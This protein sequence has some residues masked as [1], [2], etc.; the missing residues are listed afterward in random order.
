MS[1]Q[2]RSHSSHLLAFLHF[3][4]LTPQETSSSWNWRFY[5]VATLLFLGALL[6]K[7]AVCCL[8]VAI[9]VLIWWKQDRLTARDV[10]NL[11]PWFA[12]S[13]ILGLIMVRVE[14]SPANASV[15]TMPLS[16]VE[17]CLLAGRALCFYAARLFWPGKLTFVYPRWRIDGGAAWQYFFPVMALAVVVALWSLRRRIGKGPLAGVLCFAA[18]LSPVLGFCGVYYFR[19]SYVADHFQYVASIG[20]ISL[21]VCT[22]TAICLRAGHWGRSLGTVAAAI[23]LLALGWSTWGQTRI[24]QNLETLWRDTLTK[25]P[26]CWMAYSNLGDAFLLE[27]RI[28][29]AIGCYEQALRIKPDYFEAHCN[30][31]SALEQTG[32]I[33]EAIG[34][35]Q[36]ALRIKPDYIEAHN[37]LG[38]ALEQAGRVKEAIEHYEQALRID[39][40]YAEAHCNLGSALAQTGKFE[41]AIGHFEEALRIKPDFAEAHNNLGMALEQTGKV[42]EAIGHYQQALRINPDFTPAQN[43]LT[44]LQARQ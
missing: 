15:T 7:T 5:P 3:R 32:K 38:I 30:L 39:P 18:M 27:G 29:D 10:L 6:S 33:E 1:C 31:G 17:R 14:H 22:G 8:P 43:A 26:R 11:I 16:I 19:Y 23:V 25:N 40:D 35:Y 41:E 24:Y 12:A 34:H 20:L 28:S 21:A 2:P 4:P 36:Q 9:L 13:L 44:R 37:N 42:R